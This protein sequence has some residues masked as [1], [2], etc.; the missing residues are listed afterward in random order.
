MIINLSNIWLK[1]QRLK[2][3]LEASQPKVMSLK[4]TADQY[5]VDVDSEACQ[6]TREKINLIAKKNEE[7]LRRCNDNL[8]LLETTIDPSEFDISRVREAFS[9]MFRRKILCVENLINLEK[10]DVVS[11]E[12]L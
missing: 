9:S 1:L 8:E 3:Q 11:Y 6:S 2:R 10:H 5:L 7:L 12:L 4:D